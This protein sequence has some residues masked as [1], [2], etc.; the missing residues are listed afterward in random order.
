MLLK[1]GAVGACVISGTRL[2]SCVGS[3]DSSLHCSAI[4]G[5]VC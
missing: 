3:V 2:Y 1:C 5:K 4:N